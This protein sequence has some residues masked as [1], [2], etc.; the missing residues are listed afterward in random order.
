MFVDLDGQWGGTRKKSAGYLLDGKGYE[1]V[2][3]VGF[4]AD[5]ADPGI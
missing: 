1:T 2:R 3:R 5:L 4:R